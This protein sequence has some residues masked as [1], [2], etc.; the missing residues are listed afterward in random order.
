MTWFC[1]NVISQNVVGLKMR[2]HFKKHKFVLKMAGIA[3]VINILLKL[4][5]CPSKNDETIGQSEA[6]NMGY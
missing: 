5:C 2:K 4:T 6:V 1:L 3:V